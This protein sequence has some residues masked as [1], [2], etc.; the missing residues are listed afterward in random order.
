MSW[1]MATGYI[2]LDLKQLLKWC[3]DSNTNSIGSLQSRVTLVPS[4]DPTD[5]G[6]AAE[7]FAEILWNSE[8][9]QRCVIL[10]FMV[11]DSNRFERNFL[12]FIRG[13]A[14]E[15]RAEADTT[16]QKSATHI[17]YYYGAYIS[18]I[19]RRRA[20]RVK[21][22]AAAFH[23]IKERSATRQTLERF[24][25]Q[26]ST[27]KPDQADTRLK[28]IQESNGNVHSNNEDPYLPN[29][30]KLTDFL[31]SSTAFKDFR[32]QLEAFV[33]SNSRLKQTFESS[34]SQSHIEKLDEYVPTEKVGNLGFLK[35]TKHF[36]QRSFRQSIPSG[37][38]RIEWTCVGLPS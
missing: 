35:R 6:G 2:T 30:E 22:Q 18:R 19:I 29:L 12:R 25:E 28:D 8:D 13:Y 23:S 1:D 33:E 21:S 36:L 3:K 5:V 20:L 15:L 24:L 31:I 37:S 11:M 17:V 9:I 16:I 34:S 7:E 26:Q 10:G 14:S 32:T 27:K 38:Q 4:L